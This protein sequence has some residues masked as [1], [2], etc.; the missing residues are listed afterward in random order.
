MPNAD[1]L[2][3]ISARV[4]PNISFPEHRW[5]IGHNFQKSPESAELCFRSS[6]ADYDQQSKCR[7]GIRRSMPP[8]DVIQES[9]SAIGGLTPGM[10]SRHFCRHVLSIHGSHICFDEAGHHS[11]SLLAVQE[12]SVRLQSRLATSK[13]S[14][15]RI[16]HCQ[17][18]PLDCQYFKISSNLRC[19]S[20]HQQELGFEEFV[21]DVLDDEPFDR[22]RSA[23]HSVHSC[24]FS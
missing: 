18:S 13:H 15:K 7:R 22:R 19:L 4:N 20:C 21:H 12:H 2:L 11:L 17:R 23:A 9:V 1:L 14:F 16:M 6:I 8:V 3:P 5:T 24:T 10:I